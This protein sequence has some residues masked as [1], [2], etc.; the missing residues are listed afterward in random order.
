[1]NPELTLAAN[2][3]IA[4]LPGVTSASDGGATTWSVAGQLF[5]V[6]GS[7]GIEIKLEPAIAVAATRT[8]DT[9]PSPRGVEWVRFDPG[10]LDDHAAD[11][12]EAWLELACRRAAG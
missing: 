1:M 10:E 8:P 4:E 9:V 6:L 3:V 7:T 5:A 12:L 2:E 11:R